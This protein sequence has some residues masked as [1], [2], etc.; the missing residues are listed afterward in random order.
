MT[1]KGLTD[2]QFRSLRAIWISGHAY[3]AQR[4]TIAT[5]IKKGFIKPSEYKW[6]DYDVVTAEAQAL[7]KFYAD[8]ERKHF[9][10]PMPACKCGYTRNQVEAIMGDR[11]QE[12]DKWMYGQTMT[13]CE[14]KSYNHETREYEEAC[15]GVAHGGVVY[16]H[17]LRGFL[18]KRPITD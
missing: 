9:N 15:G 14:G 16:D 12:F 6:K 2:A 13:L 17:D 10:L 3:F 5:L 1:Y 11:L 8:A 18:A 4:R 7:Y